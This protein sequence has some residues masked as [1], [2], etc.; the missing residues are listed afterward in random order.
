MSMLS[1]TPKIRPST[2][3]DP[4]RW[5]SVR[6]DTSNRLRPTLDDAISTTVSATCG[7]TAISAIDPPM[8]SDR[9]DQRRRQPPPAHQT[10]RHEH[11]DQAAGAEGGVEH[12]DSRIADPQLADREHHEQHIHRPEKERL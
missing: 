2:A 9:G 11:R 3:G 1:S 8:I 6:P 5:S 10:D 12:A 4:V 7:H